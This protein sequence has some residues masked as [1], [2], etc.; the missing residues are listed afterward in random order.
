[1]R[2]KIW[3]FIIISIVF[4]SGCTAEEINSIK[5]K[6]EIDSIVEEALK[7]T[8]TPG[9]AV[10]IIENQKIQF[11]NYGYADK[12]TNVAVTSD[13]LFEL[14][15][16]SKAFTGLGILYLEQEGKI[17]LTD[18]IQTY[19]PWLH[20][21]ISGNQNWNSSREEAVV[22]IENLL[23]HT[24]GIPFQTIG[25]IPEGNSEDKLEE[26]VQQL[27]GINLD[28]CPGEKYSYATVNYDILGLIIQEVSGESYEEFIEEQILIPLGLYHTY[29]IE[30]SARRTGLLATGYKRQFF[31]S[32]AYHAP[33][34]RGNTPAGYIISS[35]SDMARWLGIQMGSIDIPPEYQA[36]IN[37]SH[38]GNSTVRA[39]E[40][41]YYGVGWNVDIKGNF[42]SHG[43]S[44]PNFSSMIMVDR[45]KGIGIC[46]LTNQNSAAPAYITD[47]FFNSISGKS[48]AK[49]KPDSYQ[50]MDTIFSLIFIFS[51]LF[52]LV[53]LILL[54]KVCVDLARKERKYEKFR[55][56][57]AIGIMLV[58]PVII[59]LG[60]CIYY[61]P[62]I[63]FARLPWGAVKVWGSV[64]IVYGSITG[65]AACSTFLLYAVLTFHFP[66]A[67]EKNY[68]ALIL[69]SVMNGLAGSLIIF[70]INESFNR[71]LQYSKELLVYFIFSLLFYIYTIKLVQGR[72]IILTNE[73]AYEKRVSMIQ[74]IINSNF[75]KIENIGNSKIYSG[76]NNDTESLL[77]IPKLIVD[78]ASNI[79]V[80]IFCLAC[81]MINNKGAFIASVCIICLNF[82]I[83]FLTSRAATKFWEKNRTIK[84]I[85]FDQMA[86]LIYGF[87][88]LLHN[89][90]RKRDFWQDM[91]KTSRVAAEFSKQAGIKFLNFRL[92]NQL[93]YNIIFGVV[94][95]IFPI[96]LVGISI[97]DLR[98]T[99]FLVFYLIG[100]FASIMNAIQGMT[101]CRVNLKRINQL[102]DELNDTEYGQSQIRIPEG[103]EKIRIT[104]KNVIYEYSN[105]NHMAAEFV[106]GPINM[107]IETGEITYITGGNGS[108]KSTL[109]KLLT[110]LYEVQKGQ[111]LLNDKPCAVED[112]NMCFT[113]VYSDYHLFKKLYGVNLSQK[114][115][116]LEKLME[117][118]NLN[119]KIIFSKTGEFD[120]AK[121]STG[122][123]KRLAFILSCL[124]DKPFMLFDEWA[125]E[126]DPTFKQ[127]FYETLLPALKKKGKGI[128]VITHDDRY[129]Y[130][131]DKIIRLERGMVE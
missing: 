100:P 96:F 34:Y 76:L 28:F 14:G 77:K 101:E 90:D 46:I 105:T 81:I 40:D 106:L 91:K 114:Q 39:V 62:S 45:T 37:K 16:M 130:L 118:M 3:C 86:D 29:I 10:T 75:E 74:K 107:E 9:A 4:I 83:S 24:S 48:V 69:L 79:L 78:F 23:Y 47:H 115:H 120:S 41:A 18:T 109:G 49:F 127:Y 117:L 30:E 110:G 52:F 73:L 56:K 51:S 95:F 13:T 124:D 129:F 123:K 38:K 82:V 8:D 54:L 64:S 1:M 43:G 94:V 26:T 7:K 44:N 102:M 72:M 33:R 68:L 50:S 119:D 89:I 63:L 21:Y 22:T 93:M 11:R 103:L 20:F 125:A 71:E 25:F 42:I 84:D 98:Q 85:Y 92:Y 35:A 97:N 113:A 17:N 5:N 99:L 121:L 122:Q 27:N 128:I 55:N 87:K 104:C 6:N 12:D 126:Q 61:L 57:R 19:I 58:I 111:M 67:Q 59:F 53:F 66:K 80:L 60:F 65:F 31:R 70:V 36:I 108:G 15:S 88:E 116:E 32:Q 131:A 112:L 2:K